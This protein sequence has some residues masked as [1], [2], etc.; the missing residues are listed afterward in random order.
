MTLNL[1]FFCFQLKF[2]QNI[3]NKTPVCI[4]VGFSVNTYTFEYAKKNIF[5]RRLTLY[6]DVNK[7]G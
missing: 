1:I 6:S 5:D 7:I 3:R 2:K 4:G